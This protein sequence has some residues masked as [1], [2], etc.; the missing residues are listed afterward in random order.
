MAEPEKGILTPYKGLNERT[1][2]LKKGELW[3]WTAGSGIGKSTAVH[4]IGYNLVMN[5]G[6]T[7]GVMALEES[8]KI[9][10]ERHIGIHLGVP[11]QTRREDVTEDMLRKAY[12]ETVGNGRYYF[13][14]HFGSTNIDNL[15]QKVR[16]MVVGL[17]CSFILLDHISIV[18]SGLDFEIGTSER[19]MIDKLM[20]R[21]RSL[22]EET[23]CGVQAIVHLKRKAQNKG[24]GYNEGGVITLSDLRGSGSL[25]QLSDG[26]IGM[27]RDQQRED[28]KNFSRL[29]VLKCRRTGDTGVADILEYSPWSG[30]LIATDLNNFPQEEKGNDNESF[31]GTDGDY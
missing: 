15:L 9:A 31:S 17:G 23:G 8:I 7:L 25:E 18:V 21:L 14:N 13:Y 10:S 24:K 2:G 1:L 4:E 22:I 28:I 3:I 27:E 30:R 19:Q 20:T 29:R 11:M 6:E 5:H 26:V 16:Y 12:E